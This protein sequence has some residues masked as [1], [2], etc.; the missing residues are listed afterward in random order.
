MG[1]TSEGPDVCGCVL[2]D[3][4]T[5]EVLR[6]LPR[7][8]GRLEEEWSSS[9]SRSTGPTFFYLSGFVF[10]TENC[11]TVDPSED[12]S[13]QLCFHQEIMGLRSYLICDLCTGLEVWSP[14]S[15]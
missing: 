6:D 11:A 4:P 12:L 10:H 5:T 8:D 2:P 14:T 7:G 1:G 15:K 3:S 13:V 9:L